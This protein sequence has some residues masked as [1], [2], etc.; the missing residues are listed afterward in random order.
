MDGYH[1]LVLGLSASIR[2]RKREREQMEKVLNVQDG[3][4][5]STGKKV[6]SNKRLRVPVKDIN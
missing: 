3:Y 1:F 5:V 6:K 2:I 4:I